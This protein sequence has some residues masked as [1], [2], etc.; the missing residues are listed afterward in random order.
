[1]CV[2]R[3]GAVD[4]LVVAVG[5]SAGPQSVPV[6]ASRA[7][8]ATSA[9]RIRRI[10]VCILVTRAP[11]RG[12]LTVPGSASDERGSMRGARIPGLNAPKWEGWAVSGPRWP[13]L[14]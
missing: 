2:P 4:G 6:N 1:M 13:G 9:M 14:R 10:P 11:Y 12:A 3:L 7:A 8:R 5:G